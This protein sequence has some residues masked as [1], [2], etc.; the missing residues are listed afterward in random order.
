MLK[1]NLNFGDF[2]RNGDKCENDI[3]SFFY[4]V[5][6]FFFEWKLN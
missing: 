4:V 2:K 1:I 5:V 3:D 6:Y